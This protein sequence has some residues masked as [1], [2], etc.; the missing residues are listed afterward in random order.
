M[1]HDLG[2]G[3]EKFQNS[4]NKD[5]P[6][7]YTRSLHIHRVLLLC[8]SIHYNIPELLKFDSSCLLTITLGNKMDE[9][10][11]GMR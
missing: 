5:H 2:V 9:E 4:E 8:Q 1:E 3:A 6:T 10:I 11:C 7:A